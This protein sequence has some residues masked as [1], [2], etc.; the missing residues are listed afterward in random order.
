MIGHH[1]DITTISNNP[2]IVPGNELGMEINKLFAYR[3]S[4]NKRVFVTKAKDT[5]NKGK[6]LPRDLADMIK[7][8]PH[9]TLRLQ[10]F[11][12]TKFSGY[13]LSRTPEVKINFRGYKLSRAQ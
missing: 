3:H 4:Q 10:S 8:K 7:D 2:I 9:T 11:A 13:K 6:S 12:G 1:V 5:Y